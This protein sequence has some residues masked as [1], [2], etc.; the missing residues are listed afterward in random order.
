VAAQRLLALGEGSGARAPPSLAARARATESLLDTSVFLEPL[1]GPSLRLIVGGVAICAY[2]GLRSDAKCVSDDDAGEEDDALKSKHCITGL[3][4]YK[5]CIAA[6]IF[7]F[8][9]WDKRDEHKWWCVDACDVAFSQDLW[10]RRTESANLD[11]TDAMVRAR[12]L[13]M[14]RNHLMN[15]LEVIADGDWK[16]DATKVQ[17]AETAVKYC[18]LGFVDLPGRDVVSLRGAARDGVVF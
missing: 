10:R 17:F 1:V 4:E 6:R 14:A 11:G 3:Y 8:A 18:A 5:Y 16:S 12:G 13:S 2:A 9:M 7:K 15:T